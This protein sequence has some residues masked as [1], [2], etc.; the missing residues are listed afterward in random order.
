MGLILTTEGGWAL[1]AACLFPLPV[2][3]RSKSQSMRV[4]TN[5]FGHVHGFEHF[6]SR[7]EFVVKG[8]AVVK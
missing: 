5:T 2:L 6:I 4:E 7:K 3:F 1:Y 8:L